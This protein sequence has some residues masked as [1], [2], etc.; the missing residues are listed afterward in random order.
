MINN[1]MK[2]TLSVINTFQISFVLDGKINYL[3]E[4]N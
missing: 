1:I 3:I 2:H 4:I